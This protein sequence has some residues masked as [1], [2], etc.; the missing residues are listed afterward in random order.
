MIK[1]IL[2]A[3]AFIGS[4]FSA[5]FYVLFKQAKDEQK[6]DALEARAE[7]AEQAAAIAQKNAELK[8][9]DEELA[10]KSHSGNKLDNFNAGINRLQNASKR[11]KERNAGAGDSGN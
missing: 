6:R 5:I 4:I 11:G 9:E 10:Q 8:K 3:L 7:K 1:K 2:A